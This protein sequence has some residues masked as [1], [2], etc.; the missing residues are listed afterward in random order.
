[1]QLERDLKF[2]LRDGRTLG[3]AVFGDPQGY[4]VM[5]FHGLPGS[6]LDGQLIEDVAARVGV[7]LIALDRPGFGLSD[8]QPGRCISD[9]PNDVIELADA[10]EVKRFSVLG[11]SGGGPYAAVCA[12]KIPHRLKSAGIVAGLAPPHCLP[13]ASLRGMSPLARLGLIVARYAPRLLRPLYQCLTW[14]SRLNPERIHLVAVA[15]GPDRFIV[16]S[17]ETRR[18]LR[19]S[20]LEAI[21]NGVDGGVWDLGLHGRA[22]DFE[23]EKISIEV[24]LWHGERDRTVPP[25][26]GHYLARTIPRC[27]ARFY[28]GDGH[29]SL[30]IKRASEILRALVN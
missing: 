12:Q 3:Y 14:V 25:F 19:D 2:T 21:R 22:W 11:V 20:F 5:Y 7:C 30:P 26:M 28:P 27:R 8:F 4:P 24:H 15:A 13:Y 29:F 18:L 23:L 17:P 16:E 10:L 6:R 9:W 1:M